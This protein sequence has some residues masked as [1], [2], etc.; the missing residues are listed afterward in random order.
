MA[1]GKICR[2][3][4]YGFEYCGELLHFARFNHCYSSILFLTSGDKVSDILRKILEWLRVAIKHRNALKQAW[5]IIHPYLKEKLNTRW[6]DIV[7]LAIKGLNEKALSALDAVEA[8]IVSLCKANKALM[9]NIRNL[10]EEYYPGI[11][12]AVIAGAVTGA[13]GGACVGSF[14]GGPFGAAVGAV[15]G[16]AAGGAGS[17]YAAG[18]YAV[19]KQN[20]NN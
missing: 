18:K 12:Q 4:T 2:T 1:S 17:F 8:A 5:E 3:A 14:G 10:G 19:N 11:L 6:L 7:D 20:K 16:L 9:E 15:V 13:A